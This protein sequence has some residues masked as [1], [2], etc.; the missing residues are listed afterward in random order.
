M[1]EQQDKFKKRVRYI[2]AFVF[3]LIA[4]VACFIIEEPYSETETKEIIEAICNCFTV[5]GVIFA[6]IAGLSYIA[7]I[8]GYDGI[9]YAFSNFGLHNIFTRQQPKTYD[10]FYEYKQM[11]DMKGRKWLPHFLIVG[12]ISLLIGL[13][14]LIVYFML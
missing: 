2:K 9:S 10:N 13:I 14:L 8:G 5:P 1:E 3:W 12:G 6:G 4:F 7:H 11:K